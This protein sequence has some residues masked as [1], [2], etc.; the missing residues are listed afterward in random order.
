MASSAALQAVDYYIQH[1]S[2]SGLFV[3][4]GDDLK[5]VLCEGPALAYMLT[6]D[7]RYPAV[8]KQMTEAWQAHNSRLEYHGTGF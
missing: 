3:Y 2:Y 8:I 4:A 6:G 1:V 5:Y 7:E